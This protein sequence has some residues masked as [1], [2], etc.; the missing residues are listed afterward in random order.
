MKRKPYMSVGLV[1]MKKIEDEDGLE[2][3]FLKE[4]QAER[5]VELD[6]ELEEGE[7]II[8]PRTSGVTL[9][10]PQNAQSEFIKLLDANGDLHPIVELT[11]KD[12][13]NRLD[14]VHVN[15]SLEYKEFQDFYD[16]LGI[17]FTE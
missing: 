9:R 10:R 17:D 7:Y 16:K 2:L 3:S 5:Q 1:I 11:V 8:L 6:I 13:F 14:S 4:F 15:K 12:I